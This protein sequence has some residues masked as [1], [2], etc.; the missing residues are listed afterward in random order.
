M[1]L[2]LCC[3]PYTDTKWPE[4]T[5]YLRAFYSNVGNGGTFAPRAEFN[6]TDADVSVIFIIPNHVSYL[7]P[8]FDPVFSA[9]GTN[10]ITIPG[11]SDPVYEAD[12]YLGI[13]GCADQFQIC[14]R[15][16]KSC[17]A[18]GSQSNLGNELLPK[19]TNLSHNPSQ[20]AS[21]IRLLFATV[22]TGTFDSV[23]GLD[24]GGKSE[25]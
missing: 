12:K 13:I 8:V 19:I 16:N 6:R 15:P 14:L 25:K 5:I 10:S 20:T 4:L 2:G 22:S 21:A 24:A 7:S 18:L 9:N 3:L 1:K 23:N 17:T 11:L